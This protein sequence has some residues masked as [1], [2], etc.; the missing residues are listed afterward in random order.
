MTGVSVSACGSHRG[1]RSAEKQR[2]YSRLRPRKTH[3]YENSTHRNSFMLYCVAGL[4]PS[5][6]QF[7]QVAIGNVIE[8]VEETMKLGVK[9][10]Y[11]QCTHKVVT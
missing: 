11:V 10:V 5:D 3:L 2:K 1:V 7:T 4:A 8:Q 6:I 9:P